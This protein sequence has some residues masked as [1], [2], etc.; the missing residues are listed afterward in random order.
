MLIEVALLIVGPFLWTNAGFDWVSRFR[1]LFHPA[2]SKDFTFVDIDDK[3]FGSWNSGGITDRSKVSKLI[4]R[5]ANEGAMAI[6]VDLDL[7]L[8]APSDSALIAELGGYR[9]HHQTTPLILV[10]TLGPRSDDPKSPILAP[11]R[12]AVY[13]SLGKERGPIYIGAAGF[14]REKDFVVRSWRLAEPVCPD[15]KTLTAFPSVELVLLLLTRGFDVS[16]EMR[17]ISF[18]ACDDW[19]DARDKTLQLGP[20]DRYHLS[21]RLRRDWILYSIPWS[22][23]QEGEISSNRQP[24]FKYRRALDLVPD[25]GLPADS[26][27]Q[28][29]SRD[30]FEGRIVVIGGSNSVSQDFYLTP[31]GAMP[32]AMVLVN[33]I[34][35]LLRQ[36]Q[37]REWELGALIISVGVG[38]VVWLLLEVARFELAVVPFIV[39][40]VAVV[41]SLLMIGSGRWLDPIGPLAGTLAHIAYK[42]LEIMRPDLKRLGWRALFRPREHRRG[43]AS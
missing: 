29:S 24:S 43:H 15:G 33:S 35:S 7:S 20:N 14:L 11:A 5:V 6:V 21:P 30:M 16:E 32:G 39:G 26:T 1:I 18:G 38:I 36:G 34:N 25:H 3:T 19:P 22:Q 2:L 28:S 12:S 41:A 17:K 8:K 40:L 13:D 4:E 42:W 37:V 23:P 27:R 31:V 9:N 10:Q